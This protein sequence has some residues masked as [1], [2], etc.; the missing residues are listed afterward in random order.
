MTPFVIPDGIGGMIVSW[1][2]MTAGITES[3]LYAQRFSASGSP[4]WP[5]AG[6]RIFTIRFAPTAE[7]SLNKFLVLRSNAVSSPDTLVV[8]GA[9]IKVVSARP[10][11]SVPG[12]FTLHR[13]YP[14]PF[15]AS[16]SICYDLA[17]SAPV[18]LTIHDALGRLVATLV[19]E[20]QHPG[21]YSAPWTPANALPG[22]YFLTL[23]VG[24]EE[25]T[26]RMLLMR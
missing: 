12:A 7:G 10:L 14:N 17:A 9:G 26:R 25:S 2:D 5:A 8:Q 3:D 21:S 22:M 20:T 11:Q 4:Q 1:E 15:H 16:T 23:R 18:M 13:N 19:D 6:S 24:A